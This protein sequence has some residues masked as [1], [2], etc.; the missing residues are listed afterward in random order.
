[1]SYPFTLTVPVDARYRT[2]G[3]EVAGRYVELMGGSAS[4]GRALGAALAAELDKLAAAD[5][6]EAGVLLSFLPG[7]SGV[8]VTLRRGGHSSVITHPLPASKG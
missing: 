2:L 7:A 8:R 1:M 4:E 3:P 5:G 6:D